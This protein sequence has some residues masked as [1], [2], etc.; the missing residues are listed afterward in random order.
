MPFVSKAQEK[1]FFANKNK[2]ES[3]G[4]NVQEWADATKGHKLPEHVKHKK[5]KLKHVGG[6]GAVKHK[7]HKI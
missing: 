2:L 7:F 6:D 3:Q 5:T 1:Y 4:V